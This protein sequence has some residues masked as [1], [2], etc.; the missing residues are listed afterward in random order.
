MKIIAPLFFIGAA[1]GIFFF[2]TNPQYQTIKEKQA[3]QTKLGSANN[4]AAQLRAVRDQLT[5]QR[6]Q[7]LDSDVNR[8]KVMLPDGVENVNLIIAMQNIAD[9]LGMTIKNP[10]V[11]SGSTDNSTVVGPNASKYGTISLSFVVS[12][13]YENFQVFLRKLEQS[14]RIVDVTGLTFS[15]N[16]TGRYDYNVTI[17]TYWLK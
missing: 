14:L 11:N 15:S 13:T 3:E 4:K 2:Y 1:L 17:Q 5:T 9:Q 10:S 16:A 8:L 12:A 7:I 6:S